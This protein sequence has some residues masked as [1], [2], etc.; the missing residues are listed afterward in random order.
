MGNK[1]D[2]GQDVE[3]SGRG[4]LRVLSSLLQGCQNM[5]IVSLLVLPHNRTRF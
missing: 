1:E 2:T 4:L 5:R 3:G